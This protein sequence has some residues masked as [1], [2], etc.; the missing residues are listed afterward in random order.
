MPPP[1]PAARDSSAFIFLIGF[2]TSLQAIGTTLAIPA[3]PDI[4][5]AFAAGPEVAQLVV[6]GYLIGLAAGHLTSG[7][8]SDQFGR[9]PVMLAGI[10]IAIVASLGCVLA[11]SIGSLIGFRA[12]QG[13]G[14]AAGMII[15]R[16]MI[17][18]SF[19]G[20][21]AMQAMAAQAAIVSIVPA[22]GPAL[23]GLML[24]AT[25]WRGVF[26]FIAVIACAIGFGIWFVLP[27]TIARLNPGAASPKRVAASSIEM[28]RRPD[29]RVFAFIAAMMYG[30][31]ISMISL[32]GYVARDSF[33][34]GPAA[35]GALIGGTALA[36]MA[37][38]IVN[39]RI[40]ARVP[41]ARMLAV[42]LAAM[43]LFAILSVGAALLVKQGGV[44]GIAAFA[45]LYGPML[46]YQFLLGF[47]FPTSIALYLKPLPHIAGTASALGASMQTIMSALMAWFGGLIY[48]GSPLA[49]GIC[50]VLTTGVAVA[51]FWSSGKRMLE[52]GERR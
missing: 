44:A 16:A 4:A 5:A 29:S 37:G 36:Y 43:L 50:Q 23:A 38:S 28:L 12:L 22:L 35:A 19:Q 30:G 9:R 17:R 26:G 32:L 21:Q 3:L 25:S 40:T 24:H 2:A 10:A 33:A 6:S 8:L 39:N 18:D 51:L 45:L 11:P 15:G 1:R 41:V 48:D 27:E 46:A 31:L 13:F 34:M 14:G 47:I 49:V 42:S 20:T 52:A 7:P